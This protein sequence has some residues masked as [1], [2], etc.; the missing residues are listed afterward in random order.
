[1]LHNT[2]PFLLT[3]LRQGLQEGVEEI[4]LETRRWVFTPIPA[5]SWLTVAGWREIQAVWLHA[6]PKA[7][8]AGP[9]IS[10]T[11]R[12]IVKPVALKI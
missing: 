6:I 12:L 8:N 1:M 9:R 11:F 4:R 2:K 5:K 7:K 3:Y 10:L